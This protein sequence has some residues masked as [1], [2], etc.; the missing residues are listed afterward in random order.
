MARTKQTARKTPEDIALEKELK[1]KESK[2]ELRK[3][4]E[5]KV[6]RVAKGRLIKSLREIR[7]VDS[8][9]NDVEALGPEK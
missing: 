7:K 6:K 2:R 1:E 4:P 3:A 8:Y 9:I 5:P